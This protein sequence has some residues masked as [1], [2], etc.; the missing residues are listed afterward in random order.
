MR[1]GERAYRE[2]RADIVSWRLVPGQVLGEVDLSERLGISRTPVREAL[3]RLTADGLTEP[4]NGRGV[5]VSALS[6]DDVRALYELRDTL[7]CRAAELAA[8]RGDP[9]TFRTLADELSHAA[10]RLSD[11]PDH[12]AYYELVDR[13]DEQID[14]AAGNPYLQQA[15]ENVRLHLARV[16]RLATSDPQRLAAAAAEHEAIARAIA[17][18]DA[19]LAV[20]TTRVHLKNALSKALGSPALAVARPEAS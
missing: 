9:E 6:A 18:G 12:P 7:D 3:S 8:Q 5:V 2:L 10:E 15:L 13:M 19:P 4:H 1:A 17:H 14:A 16:R 11:D 20:A